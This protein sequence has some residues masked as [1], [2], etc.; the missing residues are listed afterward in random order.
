MF[1]P[2]MLSPA[3][4][5]CCVYPDDVVVLVP[6]K[7]NFALDVLKSLER[8]HTFTKLLWN[9]YTSPAAAEIYPFVWTNRS[10]LNTFVVG[11]VIHAPSFTTRLLK[12]P[13]LLRNVTVPRLVN[14]AGTFNSRVVN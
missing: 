11:S 9:R 8:P 13:A 1:E 10:L 7:T 12:V 2:N 6:S 4:K 3:T 5:N 14:S